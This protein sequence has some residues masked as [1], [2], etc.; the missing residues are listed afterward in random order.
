MSGSSQFQSLAKPASDQMQS[1]YSAGNNLF[2]P[3]R[4]AVIPW[5]PVYKR[6]FNCL[7]LER[8]RFSLRLSPFLT[9]PSQVQ[10]KACS[11]VTGPSENTCQNDSQRTAH[12][13]LLITELKHITVFATHPA[14]GT[15]CIPNWCA[16]CTNSSAQTAETNS[17][18][19]QEIH[20]LTVRRKCVSTLAVFA[21]PFR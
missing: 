19:Y 6:I 11:L 16:Q 21:N 13:T 4:D 5:D 8:P 18:L 12:W 2:F 3:S 15:P 10:W 20:L 1:S 7:V 9:R 14:R 17:I